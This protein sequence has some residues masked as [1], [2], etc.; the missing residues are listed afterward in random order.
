MS[1][2][3][4]IRISPCSKVQNNDEIFPWI[5]CDSAQIFCFNLSTSEEKSIFFE[6]HFKMNLGVRLAIAAVFHLAMAR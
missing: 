4:I 2:I 3:A 6:V 5:F 1:S